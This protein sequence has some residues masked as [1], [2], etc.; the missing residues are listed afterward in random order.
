MRFGDGVREMRTVSGDGPAVLIGELVDVRDAPGREALSHRVDSLLALLSRRFGA[1][2]LVAPARKG[3][4]E[5]AFVLATPR[6]AF[7]LVLACELALRPTRLRWALATGSVDVGRDA[8]SAVGMDGPVFHRAADARERGRRD[9]LP[10]AMDL[11]GRDPAAQRLA[12]ALAALHAATRGDWTDRTAEVAA[13]HRE[14]GSQA[15]VARE[16][17][18]SASNISQTLR[19]AHQS[20]LLAAERALRAWLAEPPSR[21]DAARRLLRGLFG[22]A[23]LRSS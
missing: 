23:A 20:E 1:E 7:D 9:D 17:G 6:A 8:G 22:E 14:L 18:T 4:A 3:L 2:S 16:L 5:I 10:L 13:A 15:E 11:P 12:E 21:P 19:R